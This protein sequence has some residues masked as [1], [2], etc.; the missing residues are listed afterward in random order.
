M[1]A[2]FGDICC[3]GGGASLGMLAAGLKHGWAIDADPEIASVYQTNVG[4]IICKFAQNINPYRLE[5]VDVLW[6]S[7]PCQAFSVARSRKLQ[8]RSDADLGAD[9]L[10]DLEF[11]EVL[12]PKYVFIENVPQYALSKPFKKIVNKLY[13]LGY[14]VDFQILN[15][16]DWGVP[17]TRRRLIL[18]AVKD[19]FVPPLPPKQKWCGWY[20]AITD[21]I[22]TLPESQF[23]TW[24]IERMPELVKTSLVDGRNTIRDCTVRSFDEPAPT[25]TAH[26]LHRPCVTPKAFIVDHASASHSSHSDWVKHGCVVALTPRAQARLQTFPNTYQLPSITTLAS[27]VIGNAVPPKMVQRLLSGIE[28]YC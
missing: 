8:E 15:A 26:W 5:K 25:V 28:Q 2:I 9:I 17:Q 14:W 16:A 12:Q 27:R 10:V 23:A 11:I 13:E 20:E 7:F 18:R 3:G 22:P 6:C 1:A 24:Q 19:G 4:D 21:L